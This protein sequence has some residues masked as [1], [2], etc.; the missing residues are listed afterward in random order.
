[1]K[2]KYTETYWCKCGNAYHPH[3]RIK[4]KDLHGKGSFNEFQAEIEFCCDEM[5]EAYNNSCFGFG[6]WYEYGDTYSNTKINIYNKKG[7][8]IVDS[9]PINN[10]PFCGEKIEVEKV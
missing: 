3:A 10:C 1:M 6:R 8:C 9:L 4:R 2:V 7:E 5:E